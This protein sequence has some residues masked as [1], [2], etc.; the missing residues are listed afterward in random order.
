MISSATRQTAWTSSSVAVTLP[1]TDSVLEMTVV[2]AVVV[3]KTAVPQCGMGSCVGPPPL[4]TVWW[5]SPAQPTS[6]S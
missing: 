3:L 4:L 2:V 5:S 1:I 6:L